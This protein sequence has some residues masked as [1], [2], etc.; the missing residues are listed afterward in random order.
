MF[1]Q[2][3]MTPKPYTVLG[4]GPLLSAL[5]KETDPT[6]GW[7]YRFRIFRMT[8]GGGD[9][10]RDLQPQDVVNLVKLCRLLA[11]TFV[12]DGC[13]STDDRQQLQ[14]LAAKLDAITNKEP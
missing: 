8:H 14:E 10:S 3:P 5:W 6:V 7:Q 12:D 9:V 1:P 4:A 13:I 2:P 11:V